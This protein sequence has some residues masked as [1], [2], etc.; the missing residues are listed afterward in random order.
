MEEN[1]KIGQLLQ[2]A[3]KQKN[4][5]LE[6]VAS[7][8]K[9]N[10]NLLKALEDNNLDGL[11]N[12]TYVKGFVKN[13]A[14]ILNINTDEA[15]N[16]LERVYRDLEPEPVVE[17]EVKQQE[18]LPEAPT[19]IVPKENAIKVDEIQDQLQGIL[20]QVFTKKFLIGAA[21]V[22]VAILVIKGV[23]SFFSNINEEKDRLV[24]TKKKAS[25]IKPAESSIFEMEKTKKLAQAKLAEEKREEKK[26]ETK[27]EEPKKE[28]AA[29]VEEKKEDKNEE[30]KKEEKKE[31]E[32]E[33]A[34][35]VKVPAGKFPFVK[36]Y[37]APKDIY[38]LNEDSEDNKNEDLLP[39][40]IKDAMDDDKHNLYINAIEGDTW[41]SYQ[42]DGEDVKRYI[43][44]KGRTLF[45]QADDVILLFLGNFN[46]T[47]I[48]YN[49]KL[50]EAKTRTGVKSLIFPEDKAGDYDLPLF[51]SYNGAPKRQD[52]YKKN[53]VDEDFKADSDN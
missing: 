45:L 8:T 21:G 40:N 46:A 2:R 47:K 33:K 29:K 39:E 36:F 23:I 41:L 22:V 27:K 13:C 3:R 10:I 7:K 51:P 30:T 16:A 20:S 19:P 49:N 17:E 50:V 1:I 24:E 9:I 44:K 14:K 11:P 37:P 12:K 42:K 53:M 28:E 38:S 32:K 31:E 35:E 48:F 52:V 5:S 6:D 15:L 25:E 18:P 34:A 26:E 43:L 4:A